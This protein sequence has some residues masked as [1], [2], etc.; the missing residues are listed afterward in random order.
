MK[1]FKKIISAVLAIAMVISL[2]ACGENTK[3]TSSIASDDESK[4]V[5]LKWMISVSQPEGFEEVMEAANKYLG[6]KLNV[7]LE[8][9]CI[10]S[11]DYNNKV[12]LA[13]ASGEDVDIIW[14]SNW[15]NKYE[16]NISKGAYL[17]LDE[18]LELPELAE[19]KGY[20]SE[21]IWEA[22]EVGGV[23]YGVPMEQVMYEH[24]GLTFNKAVA[25]KYNLAAQIE[26]LSSVED[27]EDIYQVVREGEPEDLHITFDPD[28]DYFTERLT[29][30]EGFQIK[31]GEVIENVERE[32]K[33]FERMRE[34][35]EK[36]FFP[37]EI[38]TLGDQKTS[39]E[40]QQKIFS[41]FSRYL[42]GSAG[43]WELSKGYKIY[44]VPV[45]E[46]MMNRKGVQSTLN[47]IA[48]ASK[49]PVRALK[50]I[51]LMLHDEY[52]L[53]LI[54]YGLEGRDFVKDPE[55]PKRMTRNTN[56]Y[57]SEYMVG[58]QFLA[59][60]VPSY[61]DG[62][63]EETKLANETAIVDENMGFS[64]DPSSVESEISQVSAINTEYNAILNFGQD[65]DVESVFNERNEKLDMA[66]KQTI[67]DEIQRQYDEWK[68]T[69]G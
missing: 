36:G 10:E 59:Y 56:Y 45:N 52:M 69:Q 31:D 9:Q 11:A 63:W 66:G 49:N 37:K 12:Q 53:N 51:N 3:K 68:S 25:D 27:I 2:C 17:A 38:L 43:K 14:T 35:N 6:E 57:I 44:H 62:V 54:C 64:F 61:E 30:V 67:K 19:L 28:Y 21:G 29:T 13:L 46:A 50:L 32:L 65:A 16:P 23:I 24:P 20:Y 22:A 5:N 26:N 1:N 48:A 8:L 15:K 42:P 55:N 33:K 41:G 58:S 60:L 4:H 40:N 7:T 18:Y 39:L 34:W 47:S